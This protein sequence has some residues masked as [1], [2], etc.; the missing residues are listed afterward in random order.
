MADVIDC[1]SILHMIA[2]ATPD[3]CVAARAAIRAAEIQAKATRH[4][5]T[6]TLL[7]GVATV[8]AG[9]LAYAA[10][11]RTIRQQRREARVAEVSFAYRLRWLLALAAST[12]SKSRSWGNDVEMDEAFKSLRNHIEQNE[13]FVDNLSDGLKGST[14]LL[15]HELTQVIAKNAA[16]QR[17]SQQVGL[18]VL[19]EALHK[20]KTGYD[21]YLRSNTG[22]M[23][24]I[25]RALQDLVATARRRQI[26]KR[27]GASAHGGDRGA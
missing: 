26:T 6:Q 15:L 24:V 9:G 7:A 22:W 5:G 14:V 8:F 1:S 13:S 19:L 27:E 17:Y 16:G 20:I 25:R 23:V 4:A 11:G 18:E 12:L 10:A 21:Q 3:A 2:S